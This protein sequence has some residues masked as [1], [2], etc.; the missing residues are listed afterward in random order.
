MFFRFGSNADELPRESHGFEEWLQ[1]QQ[2]GEDVDDDIYGNF[3]H[4]VVKSACGEY[5]FEFFESDNHEHGPGRFSI[6]YGKMTRVADQTPVGVINGSLLTRSP[7][8]GLFAIADDEGQELIDMCRCICNDNGQL[9]KP[10]RAALGARASGAA[11]EAR[12][13]EAGSGGLLF[14]DE[15]HVLPS[16]RGKDLSL[17]LAGAMLRYLGS[18]WTLATSVV[19]PYGFEDQAGP[20][21]WESTKVRTD[22][23]RT[24][25]CRHFARLGLSQA[26]DPTLTNPS[27]PQPNP[28]K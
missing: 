18:R 9:R 7:R 19:V 2:E 20:P 3:E 4:H 13:K 15:V 25:L 10:L 28:K 22:E 8:G 21:K 24:R 26:G 17:E 23:E 11:L 16:C 1:Q 27:N 12:I 14:L 6:V 5:V